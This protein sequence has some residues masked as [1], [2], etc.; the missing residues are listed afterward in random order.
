MKKKIYCFDIDGVI[1]NTSGR[2]YSKSKPIK[3]SILKINKLYEK[4][5]Y[6]KIFTARY[7]GRNNENIKLAKNQGYIKTLSQL[8]KWKLKFHILIMGK[9][10][11]DVFVDDKAF[12]FKKNWN[13]QNF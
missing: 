7:M 8:K 10:S 5:N 2:N 12:G 3:K 9:P 4:G 6:I 11:F 13:K 1:C